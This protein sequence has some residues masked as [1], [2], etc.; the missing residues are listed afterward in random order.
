MAR[1]IVTVASFN[2][3]GRLG[4]ESTHA[5]DF[6]R[7][8]FNNCVD[9]AALQQVGANEYDALFRAL[10]A[11]G[12]GAFRPVG[13]RLQHTNAVIWNK[14]ELEAVQTHS[15]RLSFRTLTEAGAGGRLQ[16]PHFMNAV[17]FRLPENPGSAVDLVVATIHTPPT[18]DGPGPLPRRNKPRRVRLFRKVV[19]NARRRLAE[20]RR[21]Y[22]QATIVLGGDLND[23]LP[24]DLLQPLLDILT[25]A[26]GIGDRT[27]THGRRRIDFLLSQP[28]RVDFCGMGGL[29]YRV[30]RV[31]SDHAL[32]KASYVVG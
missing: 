15:Y 1:S 25:P 31:G 32:I 18:V 5:A 12:W 30:K 20:L 11:K 22:P 23:T 16:G 9:V 14:A 7:A 27:P 10:S 13:K 2:A 6:D 4:D 28:P 19:K 26:G 21:L 29:R 17:A 8:I 3:G 24:S